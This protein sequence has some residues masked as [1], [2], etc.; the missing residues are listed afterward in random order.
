MQRME[1]NSLPRCE[2]CN[3]ISCDIV[4][5]CPDDTGIDVALCRRCRAEAGPMAERIKPGEMDAALMQGQDSPEPAR[6]KNPVDT[7]MLIAAT[8]AVMAALAELKRVSEDAKR[9]GLRRDAA[10]LLETA[11]G[12][13]GAA[14]YL[15]RLNEAL[16]KGRRLPR[17][18]FIQTNRRSRAAVGATRAARKAGRL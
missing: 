6:V 10:Y 5:V 9:M 11:A 7:A 17:N 18:P 16:Y 1:N 2:G 14:H 4:T 8:E 3:R 15:A 13:A 12:Y